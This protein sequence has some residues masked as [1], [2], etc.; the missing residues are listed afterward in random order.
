MLRFVVI[1]LASLLLITVIRAVLRVILTGFSELMR[2]GSPSSP[3]NPGRPTVEAGGELK[4]DP[5]CG[6][7]IGESTSVKKTVRGEVVH[8]CSTAC[9]DKYTG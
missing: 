4:R 2:S 7:Y 1:L 3:S 6:T 5:V 9:R 8:F